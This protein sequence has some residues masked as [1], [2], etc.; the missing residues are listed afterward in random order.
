[1]VKGKIQGLSSSYLVSR[2]SRKEAG[3]VVLR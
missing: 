2:D 3:L 1:M